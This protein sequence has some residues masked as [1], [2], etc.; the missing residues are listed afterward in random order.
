MNINDAKNIQEAAGH[1]IRHKDEADEHRQIHTQ[2]FRTDF[3]ELLK[4]D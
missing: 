4:L 2:R 1:E 3:D